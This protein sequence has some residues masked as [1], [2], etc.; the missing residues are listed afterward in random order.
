MTLSL[1]DEGVIGV[2]F[3]WGFFSCPSTANRTE[4][5]KHNT[6]ESFVVS[7]GLRMGGCQGGENGMFLLLWSIS[8]LLVA[9]GDKEIRFTKMRKL[10]VNK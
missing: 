4:Q 6:S 7:V 3:Y 1:V 5:T 9:G 2:T 10:P 8:D